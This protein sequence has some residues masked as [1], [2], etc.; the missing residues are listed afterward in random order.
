MTELTFILTDPNSACS[1]SAA[2]RLVDHA[3]ELGFHL[4]VFACPAA[5]SGPRPR[6]DAP[7]RLAGEPDFTVGGLRVRPSLARVEDDN[8]GERLEPRVMQVLVALARA[9]GATVT[10]EILTHACWGGRI[11]GEDAIGRVIGKLRRLAERH[12][13]VFTVE[14]LPRIGFRLVPGAPV[15]RLDRFRAAR[16]GVH[17]FRGAHDRTRPMGSG[18]SQ[19]AA[20]RRAG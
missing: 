8:G 3:L 20:G 7:I 15:E 14:T 4:R 6:A 11:V 13:G 10:R 19:P 16:S 1:R 2:V 5:E 12:D 17:G 9:E 18:S